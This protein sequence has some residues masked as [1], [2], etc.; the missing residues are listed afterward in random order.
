[1]A[2]LG[3]IRKVIYPLMGNHFN[4]IV[5]GKGLVGSA[6]ARCLSLKDSNIAI[7]GPDEP[8][9]YNESI[10]FASHY[11][12]ARVQRIMG[13][14]ETWTKLNLDSAAQYETIQKQSGI[15]FHEPVGCLYVNPYG[16][17]QYLANIPVLAAKFNQPIK[18]FH[19]A[20]EIND[21]FKDFNF[22]AGS[23]GVFEQSPSGYIN[24]RLLV[25]AQLRI[26]KQQ[27]GIVL[28]ETIT[29]VLFTNNSFTVTSQE[30]NTYTASKVLVA[31]GSFVNYM[32]LIPERIQLKSKSEVV[33]LAKVSKEEAGKYA[34]LPSLLYEINN[35]DVEGIYMIQPV[36]YPDGE[37]YLKIGCNMPE[38]I[39]FETL[40]QVQYWFREGDSSRFAPKL[41]NEL[42][43]ILPGLTVNEYLTKK[44][45]TSYTAHR[46]PYIGQSNTKG[47]YIAGGCNGYSAMCS[48]AIGSVA[49]HLIQTGTIP[50][51]FPDHAFELKYQ[52]R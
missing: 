15:N 29:D 43:K 30:G 40:E 23:E 14:D 35:S 39:Y 34:E 27:N 11:D 51:G 33:L 12:Q 38:D 52:E 9:D 17:D 21:V 36:S 26:F 32:Q 49:A 13:K 2:Q 3:K 24:P 6:A 41:L 18:E 47:L 31:A 25:K 19:S 20:A 4:I 7:I 16:R 42:K 44:C 48:D 46:R 5:I 50:E 28:N 45:I 1:V 37:Y 22:P 10:V 8:A